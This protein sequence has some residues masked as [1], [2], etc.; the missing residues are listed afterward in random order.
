MSNKQYIIK[1]G[2]VVEVSGE[3]YKYLIK[4]DRHIRYVE[5][6]LKRNR[7]IVD[8]ENEKTSVIPRR[9][10]SL[11]RL[12]EIGKDFAD[13]TSDFQD[14]TILKIMLAEALAKLSDEEGYLIT[15]LFYFNRT[16]RELAEELGVSQ[17][18]V[19]RNKHRILKKLK[20]EISA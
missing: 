10:Q 13:S 3:I 15:Q 7:Y 17:Y 14:S 19:N 16:E 5:K 20:E 8:V 12:T 1:N 6:D 2:K 9:E 4:S 11:D 18:T